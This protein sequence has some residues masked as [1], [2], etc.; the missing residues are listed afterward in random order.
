LCSGAHAGWKRAD[1]WARKQVGGMGVAFAAAKS[2][3]LTIVCVARSPTTLGWVTGKL[4][5]KALGR[6]LPPANLRSQ[7]GRL[8][9]TVAF[10]V[11]ATTLGY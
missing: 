8:S 9:P 5:R 3:G 2:N 7:S 6:N 10:L 4:G 1:V 11:L